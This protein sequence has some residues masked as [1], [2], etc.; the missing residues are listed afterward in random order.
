MAGSNPSSLEKS[1]FVISF[2][3]AEQLA[4]APLHVRSGGA[5][6]RKKPASAAAGVLSFD[7]KSNQA[8]TRCAV[9]ERWW[10]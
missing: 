1:G 10:R 2:V 5:W 3:A 9:V 6:A 7:K 8:S 4:L